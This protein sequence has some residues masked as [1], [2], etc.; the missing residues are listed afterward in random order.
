MTA[1]KAKA[2]FWKWFVIDLIVVG[3]VTYVFEFS[4]IWLTLFIVVPL[5]LH[6]RVIAYMMEP[7]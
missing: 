2:G 3:S 4:A 1:G 7:Q 6:K 5:V